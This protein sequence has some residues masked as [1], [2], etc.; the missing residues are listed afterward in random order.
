MGLLWDAWTLARQKYHDWRYQTEIKNAHDVQEFFEILGIKI[1]TKKH[2]NFLATPS[3]HCRI[4]PYEGLSKGFTIG[5]PLSGTGPTPTLAIADLAKKFISP[6]DRYQA[7]LVSDISE[8]LDLQ[9]IG[10]QNYKVYKIDPQAPFTNLTHVGNLNI[11]NGESTFKFT[12]PVP[13]HTPH[14]VERI[15]MRFFGTTETSDTPARVIKF[16]L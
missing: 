1:D 4:A 14:D 9:A 11:T 10:P 12:E 7:L 3:V 16:E 5:M 2:Y 6:S 8:E 13:G 15:C